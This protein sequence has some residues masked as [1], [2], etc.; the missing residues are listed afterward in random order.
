MFAP[1]K[2][3]F[4]TAAL[5]TALV[6]AGLLLSSCGSTSVNPVSGQKERTVMDERA[7]IAEG[8]KGHQEVLKEYG[9]LKD[10]RLQAYVND[11][12][13][14]LAKQSERA[15]LQWKFTVL[16]SPDVNAFALPGGYVYVTRGIMAY[17]SSEADL[18]GVLGHE[19]GHVTARHGAQRAT[20]A[21]NAGLGVMAATVLGVL[22][23]SKGVQGATEMANQASQGIAAGYVAK[24]S[25]EQESQ[26]DRLGADY[27]QRINFDPRNMI[28]VIGVL[29]NQEKFAADKAKAEGKQARE[30]G[31]Y[32]ASHPANEQRLTDITKIAAQYKGNYSDEGRQRY[33]TAINGMQYG[34]SADQGVVRGRQFFHEGLNFAF[35]APVNWRI[36]NAAD[37]LT[38]VAP[39][40]AAALIV[41]GVPDNAGKTH[42]EIIRN[43]L[44]PTSGKVEARSL[45]GLR[46]THFIGTRQNEKN[47]SVAIETTVA[48]SA[49]NGQFLF[50]Y[51]SRDA[52]SL[53]KN[54]AGLQE[55]ESSFRP[56][57]PADKQLAK[58]WN[59]KLVPF[60]RGGFPELARTSA[61]GAN[62][63]QQLRLLNGVYSGGEPKLGE[64]IKIVQN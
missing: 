52:S 63:E 58:P 31:D 22:L 10:P 44:K 35:T 9:E 50:I 41:R 61:L 36:V 37:S 12:G 1:V 46:A 64:L 48:T 39:D 38:F 28:D 26:A 7:E 5:A 3:A 27:L 53:A 8:A 45:N 2:S 21:Q 57:G 19:I 33:L 25:R 15:N 11:I 32:L 55:T 54:R 20:R 13:Q 60:P 16:D 34:E 24:Y 49:S 56:M 42:E 59:L 29:R 14:R 6:G 17:M 47:Q 4:L 43:V 30:G 40:G 62:A 51:A 18:A 23:E